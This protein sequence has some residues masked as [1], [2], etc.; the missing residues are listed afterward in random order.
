VCDSLPIVVTLS[1]SGTKEYAD[2][3][4]IQE[5]IFD[6]C[7]RV[8]DATAKFGPAMDGLF[9]DADRVDGWRRIVNATQVVASQTSRLLLVIFGAEHRRL[10]AAGLA[11][12]DTCA[13]NKSFGLMVEADVKARGNEIVETTNR[14]SSQLMIFATY[15]Q[16]RTREVEGP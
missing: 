14:N 12:L 5:D 10:M 2:Y 16:A 3:T 9:K 4:E 15:V 7:D 13:V 8:S 6:V 11:L 1:S